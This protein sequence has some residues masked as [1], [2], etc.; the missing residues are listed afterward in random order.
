[1]LVTATGGKGARR[2]TP[3]AAEAAAEHVYADTPTT[4]VARTSRSRTGS[5][6]TGTPKTRSQRVAARKARARGRWIGVASFAAKALGIPA[7]AVAL[8][9]GLLYV[10]LL[11]GALSLDFLIQPIEKAIAEEAAGLR[12][13]LEAVVLRL[14]DN[15]HLQ[16]EL[17]NVRVADAGDTPLVVAPS[18]AISLSRSALLRGRI[19]PESVDLVSPRLSLF[20]SEDGVLSLKFATPAELPEADRAKPAGSRDPS[21]QCRPHRD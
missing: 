17:K 2:E 20:Y 11:H 21:N 12:V 5:P 13:R 3:S 4:G 8:I 15:G 18:A 10:K 6:R 16:F 7:F 9:F 19:A 1:M 14:A